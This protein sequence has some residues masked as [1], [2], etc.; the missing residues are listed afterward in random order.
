MVEPRRLSL[1]FRT[2]QV[3]GRPRKLVRRAGRFPS[4][5]P[6]SV[7]AL[8]LLGRM[9]LLLFFPARRDMKACR[10][11]SPARDNQEEALQCWLV[12]RS[13]HLTCP[14]ISRVMT[15]RLA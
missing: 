8:I 6:H 12:S 1:R 3:L 5:W 2:C 9:G 11:D 7:R 14:H 10:R 4:R 13:L 15:C